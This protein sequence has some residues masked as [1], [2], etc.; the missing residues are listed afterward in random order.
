MPTQVPEP[1]NDPSL[2]ALLA[3]GARS[4]SGS[5]SGVTAGAAFAWITFLLLVTASSGAGQLDVYVQQTL[6]GGH[7]WDD[8]VHFTACAAGGTLAEAASFPVR[9]SE[10]GGELHA[11][12]DATL[13][14][15]TVAVTVLG[16]T[17]RVKWT[18]SGGAGTYSFQVLAVPRSAR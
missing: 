6:D 18:V 16:R 12:R 4:V 8:L 17:F 10:G 2:V 5:D 7:N 14:A 3:H 13:G 15:A 11:L 1:V 9:V